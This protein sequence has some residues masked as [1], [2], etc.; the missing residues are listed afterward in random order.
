MRSAIRFILVACRII[1]RPDFVARVQRDHPAPEQL[2]PGRL[3]V[4]RDG[5]VEKWIC[6]LCPGGCGEKVMLNLSARKSPRWG[7]TIDWLNRPTVEP[8]VLQVNGCRCHFWIRGGEIDWC[9]D[10]G[11]CGDDQPV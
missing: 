8:S 11:C 6:F 10:S 1:P 5:P 7:V 2:K 3:V 9:P 4:V